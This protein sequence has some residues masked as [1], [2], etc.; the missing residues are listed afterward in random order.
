MICISKLCRKGLNWRCAYERFQMVLRVLYT[1]NGYL[2][3]LFIKEGEMQNSDSRYDDFMKQMEADDGHK[4]Y[5]E[6]M[7]SMPSDEEIML[8]YLKKYLKERPEKRE[9]AL[10]WHAWGLSYQDILRTFNGSLKEVEK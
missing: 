4:E 1:R 9:K 6:R 3:L 7:Q 8:R 2:L 10:K 5:I